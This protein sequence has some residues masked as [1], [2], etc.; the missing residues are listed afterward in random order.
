MN[1]TGTD[2]ENTPLSSGNSDI[3]ERPDPPVDSPKVARRLPRDVWAI[4]LGLGVITLVS[5]LWGLGRPKIL[6]FDEVYYATQAWEVGRHGVEQGLVVHPPAAKWVMAL[7]IRVLGFT[8]WGWRIMAVLAGVVV[9]MATVVA[10]YRL[11]GSRLAAGLAGVLVCTDG[12]AFTTGRL[13]LLDGFVAALLAVALAL[14]AELVAR[15]L[16]VPLRRRRSIALGFVLGAAL[17][18]KWSAAPVLV[19]CAVVVGTLAYRSAGTVSERRREVARAAG[20]L[21]A[22]PLGC[23]VLAYVPT[24]ANFDESAVGRELCG[25]TG[26]CNPWVGERVGAIVRNQLDVLDFHQDLEPQNRYAHN[27]VSWVFQ[28]EPVVLLSSNCPS[29]DPVC[30]STSE[31]STRRIVSIGNPI[32]WALG[33]VAL[34]IVLLGSLWQLDARRA[35]VAV[36]AAALWLPWVVR[37]RFDVIPIAPARP[38]YSFYATPLV[39]VV[40]IAIA[41]CW[42][43]LR[44]RRRAVV[45]IALLVIAIGGAALLYPLWTA[46]PVSSDYL[47]GLFEP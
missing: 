35:L 38:G 12:I 11:L 10:A 15:P 39:P 29:S 19:V 1:S 18:T 3:D 7:G 34:L 37:L 32:I 13:A 44:G 21:I 24:L 36:W 45:G 27:A 20:W 26:D 14:T 16:D 30:G 6:V 23:Y 8:P 31:E 28:T 42:Q 4:S 5:R 40:A 46:Q 25:R 2:T 43:L 33:T 41:S 9:V 22:L 17:A 47:Q